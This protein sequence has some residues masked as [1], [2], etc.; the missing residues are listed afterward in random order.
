MKAFI[1]VLLLALLAMLLNRAGL[2]HVVAA[3]FADAD[4]HGWL[5]AFVIAVA[6][7]AYVLRAL[8]RCEAAQ[9]RTAVAR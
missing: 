3:G 5:Y 8:A 4:R 1:V 9:R 7:M 2:S 6:A